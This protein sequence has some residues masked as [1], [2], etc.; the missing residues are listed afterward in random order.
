M[1]A[2]LANA[3]GVINAVDKEDWDTAHCHL[4]GLNASYGRN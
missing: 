1:R 4:L 2:T 3:Y